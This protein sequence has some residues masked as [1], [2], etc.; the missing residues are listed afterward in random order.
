LFLNILGAT[1]DNGWVDDI[2]LL[3]LQGGS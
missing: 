2:V 3:H 1:S